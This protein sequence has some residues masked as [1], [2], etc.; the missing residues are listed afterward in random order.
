MKRQ[1]GEYDVLQRTSD[2]YFDGNALLQQWNNNPSNK[3]RRLDKFINKNSTIVLWS[4]LEIKNSNIN[5]DYRNDNTWTVIEINKGRNTKYG[6]EPDGAWMNTEMF[7]YFCKYINTKLYSIIYNHLSQ[8]GIINNNKIE[9]I[10]C[11]EEVKLCGILKK[12]IEVSYPLQQV[13]L[14]YPCLNYKYRLDALIELEQKSVYLTGIDCIHYTIIEYDESQHDNKKSQ[15]YD[16]KREKEVTEYLYNLAIS[17]NKIPE[18]NI[19]RV[20]KGLEGFFY[21]YAIPYLTYIDTSYCFDQM[22]EHLD[23]RVLLNFGY[24]EEYTNLYNIDTSRYESISKNIE[25]FKK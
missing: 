25:N 5:F 3:R 11:R 9:V 2:S 10:S 21:A 6:R 14:Q 15:E 22:T 18:V 20:K 4:N 12:A 17:K 23:Y 16:I 24:G 7:L 1:M 13:Y 19:L 8:I